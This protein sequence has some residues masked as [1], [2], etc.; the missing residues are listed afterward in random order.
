MSNKALHQQREMSISGKL[1][2][3]VALGGE[4]FQHRA[5]RLQ[6]FLD[7]SKSQLDWVQIGAVWPEE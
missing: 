4:Q 6:P 7:C 5:M 3:M 1:G 2:Q